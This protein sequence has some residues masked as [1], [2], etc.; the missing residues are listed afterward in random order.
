MYLLITN[1]NITPQLST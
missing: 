1:P